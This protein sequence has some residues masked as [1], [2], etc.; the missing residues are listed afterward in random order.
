MEEKETKWEESER[1]CTSSSLGPIAHGAEGL[2]CFS[3]FF[4]FSENDCIVW[5][6]SIGAGGAKKSIFPLSPSFHFHR[7]KWRNR[8]F[9][10]VG[11]RFDSIFNVLMHFLRT[12]MA[13]IFPSTRRRALASS[14]SILFRPEKTQSHFFVD[15]GRCWPTVES[16]SLHFALWIHTSIDWDWL[17][18]SIIVSN[19]CL[20]LIHA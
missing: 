3:L 16:K 19:K 14:L 10:F 12:K 4:C 15:I 2:I 18:P 11:V 13:I 6:K 7:S 20:P 17:K 5:P 9:V 8:K 1:A